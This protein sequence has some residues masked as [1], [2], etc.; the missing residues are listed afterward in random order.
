[1]IK[2]ITTLSRP[3]IILYNFRTSRP[4]LSPTSNLK[5]NKRVNLIRTR[6][7]PELID[8]INTSS[9]IIGKGIILFTMF[10]CSMNWI[11][12]RRMRRAKKKKQERW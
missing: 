7:S 11:Y 6:L 5:F 10:Y 9:Y 12:Y 3:K 1:M 8:S 2:H 4:I